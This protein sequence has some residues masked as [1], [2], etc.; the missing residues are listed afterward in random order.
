MAKNWKPL[1]E[2]MAA[3]KQPTSPDEIQRLLGI[4]ERDLRQADVPGLHADGE[5]GFLYNTALQLA[6]ILV[7]LRG[8][9][10]GGPGHHKDTLRLARELVPR[11][12]K[13]TAALLDHARR[14]RNALTYDQAGAIAQADVNGLREAI[15]VLR[16]WVLQQADAYLHGDRP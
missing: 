11:E 7:R 16:P 14:K 10:F 3:R 12:L 6:T 4:V 1:G 2:P 15:D 13:P 8:E 9:R 5:F